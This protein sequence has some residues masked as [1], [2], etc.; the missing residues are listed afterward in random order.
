MKCKAK[1]LTEGKELNGKTHSFMYTHA[2]THACTHK[3]LKYT[4]CPSEHFSLSNLVVFVFA[5]LPVFLNPT[6]FFLA[7]KFLLQLMRTGKEGGMLIAGK[8]LGNSE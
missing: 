5:E 7:F 1:R 4:V 8:Q 3:S 6:H 2:D